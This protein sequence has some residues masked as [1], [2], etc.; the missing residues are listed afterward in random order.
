[1]SAPIAT[2]RPMEMAAAI[3]LAAA[4]WA[5]LNPYFFWE[6][7]AAL[8]V[9]AVMA[10]VA[11]ALLLTTH[12]RRPRGTE[13]AGVL[14][15]SLFVVYITIQPRTDGGHTR[16][17]G[18]LPTLWAAALL[19]EEG[20]RRCLDLFGRL[21]AVSLIPGLLY[22]F[23]AIA[24]LPLTMRLIEHP[25]PLMYGMLQ[26]PGAIFLSHLNAALLPWGGVLFRLCGIYDEPGMVGTISGLLLAAYAYRFTSW[27]VF[28]LYIGGVLS[29]SLAFAVL[30]IVG[31]AARA[32]FLRVG[33]SV[34]AAVPVAAAGALTAGLLAIPASPGTTTR[35]QIETAAGAAREFSAHVSPA[36]LMLRHRGVSGRVQPGLR[37]LI[38]EYLRAG[39]RT[40]LF[41]IASDATAVRGGAGQTISRVYVDH[42]LLGAALLGIGLSLLAWRGWRLSGYAIPVA[43]LILLFALSMY[44]RPV[45]WLPYTLIILIC[46]MALAVRSE[47]GWAANRFFAGWRSDAPQRVG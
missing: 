28:V 33:T 15:L 14:T 39:W 29:F 47:A 1:M 41:G 8:I 44:Q 36:T 10:S 27:K 7:N 45:V 37:A 31:L 21:F 6:A 5:S 17:I 30:T 18:V 32:V 20:R 40:K 26:M 38:D 19:S 43:I 25:N 3:V 12:P 11:V 16:W 4:A 2:L 35:I 46:G 22:S 24:G 34:A 23:A 42:G 9:S 13:L